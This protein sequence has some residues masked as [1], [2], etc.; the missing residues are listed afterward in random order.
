MN[1]NIDTIAAALPNLAQFEELCARSPMTADLRFIRLFGEL[2]QVMGEGGLPAEKEKE[3]EHSYN[4][5]S[6]IVSGDLPRLIAE[7]LEH[8]AGEFELSDYEKGLLDYVRRNPFGSPGKSEVQ[9]VFYAAQPPRK[10]AAENYLF[11]M[12]DDTCA[13]CDLV[14]MGLAVSYDNF[15][16]GGISINLYVTT[17][18]PVKTCFWMLHPCCAVR[19]GPLLNNKILVI[20]LTYDFLH[21]GKAVESIR[22][23]ISKR[24]VVYVF[25]GNHLRFLSW[26]QENAGHLVYTTANLRRPP[27]CFVLFRDQRDPQSTYVLPIAPIPCDHVDSIL[28]AIRHVTISEFADEKLRSDLDTFFFWYVAA[29][30]T[31]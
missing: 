21:G 19:C 18:P 27:V 24:R 28:S 5:I 23:L 25:F 26:T 20:Y 4:R 3:L 13:R 11:H 16:Y 1:T 10:A 9:T 31:C 12:D 15:T 30:V 2:E 22:T 17:P 14:E 8:Q 7:A 29:P 6:K